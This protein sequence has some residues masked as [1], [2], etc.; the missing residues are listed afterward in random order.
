M[1]KCNVSLEAVVNFAV[2]NEKY[3]G[4]WIINYKKNYNKDKE[5]Q[6]SAQVEEEEGEG[7]FAE[8]DFD[9]G[10]IIP[11]TKAKDNWLH[12]I[13]FLGFHPY[14]EIAFLFISQSRTIAYHLNSSKVQD[15][16]TINIPE[17]ENAFLYT[18][19]WMRELSEK[20]KA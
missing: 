13:Y 17:M 6:P 20:N 4:P 14:K 11:Q 12:L 15:L 7:E 5:T 1:L 3:D 9:N 10:C 16:G 8:W 19:C 2:D 18:P